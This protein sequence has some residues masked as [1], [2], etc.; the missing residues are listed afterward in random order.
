MLPEEE[1]IRRAL[2][3]RRIPSVERVWPTLRERLDARA[4]RRP[5]VRTW[6]AVAVFLV[7]AVTAFRDLRFSRRRLPVAGFVV[8][9]VRS[10]DRPAEAL[11][12][13]PDARTLMVIV[14]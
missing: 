14:R 6:M 11:V 8:A 3:E 10:F 9:N 7:L 1:E 12:L 13:Q 4:P 2:S 5:N